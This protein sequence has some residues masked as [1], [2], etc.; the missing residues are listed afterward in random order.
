LAESKPEK[1]KSW[2]PSARTTALLHGWSSF[3]AVVAAVN[4]RAFAGRL[5]VVVVPV[6]AASVGF[7]VDPQPARP[8]ITTI[9]AAMRAPRCDRRARGEWPCG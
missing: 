3:Q 1:T 4:D 6:R 5:V 8:Q 2:L 7:R 9:A